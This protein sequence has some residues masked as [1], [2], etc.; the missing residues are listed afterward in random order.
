[1]QLLVEEAQNVENEAAQVRVT[2]QELVQATAAIEAR[3][4]ARAQHD[5]ATIPI[6]EAVHQLN[7][8]ATPEEVLAEVQAQRSAKTQALQSGEKRNTRPKSVKIMAAVIALQFAFIA[9]MGARLLAVNDALRVRDNAYH[10]LALH[11][12]NQ[13]TYQPAIKATLSALHQLNPGL[14]HSLDIA[15]GQTVACKFDTLETLALGAKPAD[16]QTAQHPAGTTWSLLRR[17]DKFFVQG[18][19]TPEYA[20]L[21]MNGHSGLVFAAKD[22]DREKNPAI[23]ITLPAEMFAKTSTYYTTD[24]TAAVWVNTTP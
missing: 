16:V 1:M 6:G 9:F 18:W 10:Q 17:G 19:T 4:S 20:E 14:S 21:L 23:P 5:A 11:L 15:N 22:I 3:H 8:E 13:V 24:S 7:L 12:P 2:P